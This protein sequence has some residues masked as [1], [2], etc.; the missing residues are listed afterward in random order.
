MEGGI[1][2]FEL[3]PFEDEGAGGGAPSTLSLSHNSEQLVFQKPIFEFSRS[4]K[5]RVFRT[6]I[7]V[8]NKSSQANTTQD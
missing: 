7:P 2:V 5:T 8:T 1:S 4:Y 3:F 6:T